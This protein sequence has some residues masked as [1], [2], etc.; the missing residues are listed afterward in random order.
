MPVQAFVVCRLAAL[1]A[2]AVIRAAYATC[3]IAYLLLDVLVFDQPARVGNRRFGF[4]GLCHC[5]SVVWAWSGC[6]SAGR[7]PIS[8]RK[9]VAGGGGKKTLKSAGV[10]LVK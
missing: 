9:T 3:R 1:L 6:S 5:F 8:L 7:L 4:A 2:G 10:Y